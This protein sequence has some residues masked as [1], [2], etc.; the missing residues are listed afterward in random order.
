MKFRNIDLINTM[1]LVCAE[2][3]TLGCGEECLCPEC[4]SQSSEHDLIKDDF[5]ERMCHK[6]T[7]AQMLLEKLSPEY[8][9]R[10]EDYEIDYEDVVCSISYAAH[11]PEQLYHSLEL[12][13]EHM[14]E[15]W[16]MCEA[17]VAHYLLMT[18][19]GDHN[20][21]KQIEIQCDGGEDDECGV[22]CRAAAENARN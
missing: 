15:L 14:D 7:E 6:L 10:F 18:H 20:D 13:H 12:V 21:L 19:P 22:V 5:A 3:D 16:E 9:I 11:S 4:R 8:I 2:I 17:E 1:I